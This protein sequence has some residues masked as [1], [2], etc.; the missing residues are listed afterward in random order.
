MLIDNDPNECE[1]V[2]DRGPR[3]YVYHPNNKFVY[4]SNEQESSVTAYEYFSGQISEI[5]TKGT[6]PEQYS[7][8]NTCAQIRMTPN[9]KYLY[10]PNRGHA[11]IAIYSVSNTSGKLTPVGRV[12]TEP[13][14]RVLNIDLSGQYLYSA[15]LDSGYVSLFKILENGN[16]EYVDRYEVG[17]EPMWIEIVSVE[18]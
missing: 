5:D 14:P 12:R 13:T 16:L 18:D 4:F 8:S 9:G 1:Q 6:L 3:H 7:G 11:S 2:A 10:A 15:G 17:S